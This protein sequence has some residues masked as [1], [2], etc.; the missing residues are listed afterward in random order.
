MRRNKWQNKNNALG[1][2]Q[3][4]V[5]CPPMATGF[6]DDRFF[7]FKTPLKPEL[8]TKVPQ[9]DRFNSESI[10]Q[11]LQQMNDSK[12]GLWIDL[13]N[14]DR[15]YDA[16]HIRKLG[17]QYE[18]L[19]CE[20][21]GRPP[22]RYVIYE[23]CNLVQYFFRRNYRDYVAVHCTHGFNR[24]GFLICC[25]LIRCRKFSAAEAVEEFA[26]HR[27]PGIY[28][29]SYINELFMMTEPR[30]PPIKVSE[31]QWLCQSPNDSSSE[32]RAMNTNEASTSSSRD[33]QNPKV[34]PLAVSAGET[35]T[36]ATATAN[37]KE[38]VESGI[39][40][41]TD[42]DSK[43]TRSLYTYAPPHNMH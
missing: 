37:K 31:P 10:F 40:N 4:W 42:N 12:I 19:S 34:N 21:H 33:N 27:R 29:Q 5:G 1:I 14:T 39:T 6:V 8:N 28:R 17:I 18:K 43:N 23:F 25:Y 16:T 15:Y 2:P 26:K 35:S 13:T 41:D 24:T 7:V 22:S 9:P 36:S 30:L 11:Q 3:G 20:G 32:R 38:E